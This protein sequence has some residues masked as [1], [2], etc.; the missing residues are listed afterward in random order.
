MPITAEVFRVSPQPEPEISHGFNESI[1]FCV[2][3]LEYDRL[4]VPPFVHHEQEVGS[5]QQQGLTPELWQVWFERVVRSQHLILYWHDLSRSRSEW[6]EDRVESFQSMAEQLQ[7]SP[8]W[9]DSEIDWQANR[10]AWGHHYDLYQAQAQAAA[11]EAGFSH[12]IEDISPPELF[13][14]SPELRR[15]IDRLWKQYDDM[16]VV[17]RLHQQGYPE[18]WQNGFPRISFRDQLKLPHLNLFQIAYATPV[19]TIVPSCSI[20]TSEAIEIFSD[21]AYKDFV[22]SFVAML[23]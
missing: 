22:L 13:E 21:E 10:T 17:R 7:Q 1:D 11:R 9:D 8:D 4:R 19:T 16:E 15:A 5:L 23:P 20:V 12:L 18:R 14:G 3:V 6:I 2:F